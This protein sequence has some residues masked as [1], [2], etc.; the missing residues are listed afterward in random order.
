MKHTKQHGILLAACMLA[1][2]CMA[3]FSVSA[4]QTSAR[5]GDMT[6]DGMVDVSDVTRLINCILGDDSFVDAST[7]DINNDGV[8]DVSDVTS[9]IKLVL[10]D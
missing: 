6:G 8:V 3:P 1:A 4:D 5:P 7:P 10:A 2:S 9:L